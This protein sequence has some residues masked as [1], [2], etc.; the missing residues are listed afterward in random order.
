MTAPIEAGGND[1]R[2]RWACEHFADTYG[3]QAVPARDEH[4]QTTG[5]IAVN[6]DDLDDWF[7]SN[8]EPI[9]EDK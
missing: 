2:A 5:W 4:G 3:L 7:V 6:P 9:P 1:L 8:T